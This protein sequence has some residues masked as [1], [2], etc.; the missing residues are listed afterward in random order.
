[1]LAKRNVV[2]YIWKSARLEGLNVTYPEAYAIYEQAKLK[3]VDVDTVL[4]I[5]NLKR[6][7][8]FVFASLNRSFDLEFLKLLHREVAHGEAISCGELRTGDVG[9]G[10]TSYKP[11]IPDEAKVTEELAKLLRTEDPQERAVILMLW[12]MK[13]QLFWDGNKRT[14]ML[15]ANK[16]MIENGCGVI[17]VPNEKILEFNEYLSDYY[18]NDTLESI[19]EFIY[20]YCVDSC[21]FINE[22]EDSAPI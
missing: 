8:Q 6:A 17:S 20:T 12:G 2:D 5:I 11:P 16:I 15:A 10:G 14:S 22:S 9:I 21:N 19:R 1:L 4:K 3:N 18:E 13:S 7:W